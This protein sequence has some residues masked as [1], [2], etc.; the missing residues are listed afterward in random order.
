MCVS[1]GIAFQRELEFLPV[2]QEIAAGKLSGSD[3]DVFATSLE[4][5]GGIGRV[6]REYEFLAALWRIA[7]FLRVIGDAR[8]NSGKQA[9]LNSVESEHRTTGMERS[10]R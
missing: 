9:L 4:G 7:R 5:W 8:I 10:E 2:L 6:S 1:E 3:E